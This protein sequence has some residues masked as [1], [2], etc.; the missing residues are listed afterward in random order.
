MLKVSVVGYVY[1]P[2]ESWKNMNVPV[3]L[4][5]EAFTVMDVPLLYMLGH[6]AMLLAGDTLM[7]PNPMPTRFKPS[8]YMPV[9]AALALTKLWKPPLG[10]RKPAGVIPRL[11]SSPAISPPD[12]AGTRAGD[13]EEVKP[14]VDCMR[15]SSPE[16]STAP[17]VLL[18]PNVDEA[19]ATHLTSCCC[20][21]PGTPA[22]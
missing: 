12:A 2:A 14:S 17:V 22:V 10:S 6:A 8:A 11:L 1:V 16:G 21:P 19:P 15:L 7:L 3:A 9:Q 5:V 4:V 18:S 13:G 20:T